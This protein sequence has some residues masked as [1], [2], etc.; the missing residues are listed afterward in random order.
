MGY[1]NEC[2]NSSKATGRSLTRPGYACSTFW[3]TN[4]YASATCKRS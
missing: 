4:P 3:D 1:E 2:K